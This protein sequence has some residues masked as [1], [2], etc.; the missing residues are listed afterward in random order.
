VTGQKTVR[1]KK[2]ICE[3]NRPIVWTYGDICQTYGGPNNGQLRQLPPTYIVLNNIFCHSIIP[4]ILASFVTMEC[5]LQL[6]V[7]YYGSQ[8]YEHFGSHLMT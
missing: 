2:D 8:C 1:I 4:G 3:V 5:L 6:N 7:V